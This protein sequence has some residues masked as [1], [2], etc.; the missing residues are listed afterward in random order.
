[1]GEGC[2]NKEYERER[3]RCVYM[4]IYHHCTKNVQSYTCTYM[5]MYM[6]MIMGYIIN[7]TYIV[8][9]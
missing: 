9:H 2:G 6:Y 3:E 4:L 1:M 5:Y 7:T 8:V